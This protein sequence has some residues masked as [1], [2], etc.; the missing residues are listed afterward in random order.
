MIEHCQNSAEK[1]SIEQ[2]ILL[3]FVNLSTVLCPKLQNQSFV[4]NLLFHFEFKALF[5]YDVLLQRKFEAYF[6]TCLLPFEFKASFPTC[7]FKLNS[8]LRF[9]FGV[10]I[11]IRFF[12]PTSYHHLN[13]KLRSDLML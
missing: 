10:T 8:N 1:Y 12:F 9:Q 5:S 4:S 6:P 11:W 2:P 7:Y 3:S 13:S